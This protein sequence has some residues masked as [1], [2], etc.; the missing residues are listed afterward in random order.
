MALV[1]P[2]PSDPYSSPPPRRPTP[3]PPLYPAAAADLVPRAVRHLHLPLPV[4]LRHAMDRSATEGVPSRRHRHAMVRPSPPPCPDV[5]FIGVA[6]PP[7][8]FPS[9][10]HRRAARL[11]LRVDDTHHLHQAQS[12]ARLVRGARRDHLRHARAPGAEIAPR[13]RRDRRAISA[14]HLQAAPWL[15]VLTFRPFI[16]RSTR[17]S[18]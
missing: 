5:Y 14:A 8:T 11:H 2:A 3:D 6:T 16:R 9:Q 4:H 10:Q 12:R 17:P 13:S 7:V 15:F 1:R 18:D